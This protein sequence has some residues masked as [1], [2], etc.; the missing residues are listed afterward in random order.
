MSDEDRASFDELERRYWEAYHGKWKGTVSD[1]DWYAI[2]NEMRSQMD[3]LIQ[4]YAA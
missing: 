3:Y 2:V 4:K 1:A